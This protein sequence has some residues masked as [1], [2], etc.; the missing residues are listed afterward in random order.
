MPGKFFVF[1]Y[2]LRQKKPTLVGTYKY[3]GLPNESTALMR[4]L[5]DKKSKNAKSTGLQN[6]HNESRF[7]LVDKKCKVYQYE[8]VHVK[9]CIEQNIFT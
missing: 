1:R 9:Y 5:V 8:F 3:S 7:L 4:V 6:V 2:K